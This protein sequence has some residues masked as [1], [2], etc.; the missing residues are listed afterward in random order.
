MLLCWDRNTLGRQLGVADRR[1]GGRVRAQ[2]QSFVDRWQGRRGKVSITPHL[3]TRFHIPLNF[4][5]LYLFLLQTA[6][7]TCFCCTQ[8]HLQRL[9]T[10]AQKSSVLYLGVE[11]QGAHGG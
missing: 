7:C 3:S 1:Y 10:R 8:P 9:S 11:E 2:P 6:C 5:L 4:F